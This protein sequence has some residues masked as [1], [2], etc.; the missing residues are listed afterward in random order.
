VN[1]DRDGSYGSADGQTPCSATILGSLVSR[2]LIRQPDPKTSNPKF[3]L[4]DAPCHRTPLAHSSKAIGEPPFFLGASV[5]FALKV[6]ADLPSII[7]RRR[8]RCLQI[9]PAVSPWVLP[10]DSRQCKRL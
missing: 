1:H 4:Q 6:P 5:F 7:C 2:T 9:S 8:L 10:S 3:V